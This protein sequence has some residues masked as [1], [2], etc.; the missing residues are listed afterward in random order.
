VEALR[1]ERLDLEVF[2]LVF[3]KFLMGKCY[4]FLFFDRKTTLSD[5]II[6]KINLFL[7]KIISFGLIEGYPLNLTILDLVLNPIL[8]TSELGAILQ[9]L[10][11]VHVVE[12][13]PQVVGFINMLNKIQT[14]SLKSGLISTTDIASVVA[15]ILDFLLCV[16]LLGELINNNGSNNIRQQYLEESPINQV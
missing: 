11:T 7:G 1:L 15:L 10:Q 9:P 8:N 3:L 14:L 6:D 5:P 13:V 12:I 4:G 16:T 2:L